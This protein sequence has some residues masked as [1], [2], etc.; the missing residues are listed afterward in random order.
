MMGAIGFDYYTDG[1]APGRLRLP[2]RTRLISSLRS[3]AHLRRGGLGDLLWA[4]LADQQNADTLEQFRGRVHAFGKKDVRLHVF[5]VNLYFAG[6][7]DRW[8][9]RVAALHAAHQFGAVEFRHH[10]V[11]QDEV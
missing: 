7:D 6:K 10:Q 2:R 3:R 1:A 11:T 8:N 9:G 4:A 5:V